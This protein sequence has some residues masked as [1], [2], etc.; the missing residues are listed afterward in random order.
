MV[1]EGIADNWELKTIRKYGGAKIMMMEG[2]D[3]V[4]VV[5]L[6]CWDDE[7][8]SVDGCQRRIQ[9]FVR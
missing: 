9:P 1:C 5:G 4:D 6:R 2:D 8:G 3:E 7:C